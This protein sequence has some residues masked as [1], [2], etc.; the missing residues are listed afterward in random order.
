MGEDTPG[1][2]TPGS[3]SVSHVAVGRVQGV[4]LLSNA[5]GV[6]IAG[7]WC[8][9]APTLHKVSL[10]DTEEALNVLLLFLQWGRCTLA[11]SALMASVARG[12]HSTRGVT[13][14]V[15]VV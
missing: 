13:S 11:A 5:P 1:T 4:L 8:C 14:W 2:F 15:G 10:D 3:L 6:L 12:V 7:R 9:D